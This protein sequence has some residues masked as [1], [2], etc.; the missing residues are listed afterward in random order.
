[1]SRLGLCSLNMQ[2]KIGHD[3]ATEYHNFG[4]ASLIADFTLRTF[5]TA[6]IRNMIH[7]QAELADKGTAVLR[8]LNLRVTEM[9]ADKHEAKTI[10]PRIY[11]YP[12]KQ[13]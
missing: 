1:M 11:S 4:I 12:P 5:I 13:T 10:R 9:L 8:L 3:I 7:R 6:P 2:Y